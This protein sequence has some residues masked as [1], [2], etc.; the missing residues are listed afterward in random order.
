[1]A[2]S[3]YVNGNTAISSTVRFT[4]SNTQ[5][6]TMKEIAFQSVEVYLSGTYSGGTRPEIYELSVDTVTMKKRRR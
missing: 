6:I 4:G 1:M 5:M 3:F 2:V